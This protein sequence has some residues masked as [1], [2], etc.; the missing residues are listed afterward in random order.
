[1]CHFRDELDCQYNANNTHDNTCYFPDEI[2]EESCW[3]LVRLVFTN[4]TLR[5]ETTREGLLF[6]A[7]SDILSR[8][9]FG[10]IVTWNWE[11]YVI[12]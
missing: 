8:F 10:M 9:L 6:F 1:M 7:G 12:I 3:D 11:H 2:S 4:L 5:C